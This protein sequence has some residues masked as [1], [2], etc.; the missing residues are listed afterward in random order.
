MQLF[1]TWRNTIC[2]AH[3]FKLV[4]PADLAYHID[5]DSKKSEADCFRISVSS[6]IISVIAEKSSKRAEWQCD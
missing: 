4:L 5:V 6:A 3:S 2:I 1:S